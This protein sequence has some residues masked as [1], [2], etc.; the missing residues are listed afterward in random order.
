MYVNYFSVKLG[1]NKKKHLGKI[2][3][4]VLCVS[5]CGVWGVCVG[6]VCM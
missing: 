5:G 3:G 2:V 6:V 4:W 1:K